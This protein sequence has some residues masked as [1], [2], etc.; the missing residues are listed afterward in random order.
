MMKML[1]KPYFWIPAL[2]GIGIFSGMFVQKAIS[3]GDDYAQVQKLEQAFDIINRQYVDNVDSSKLAENAIEGMLEGLDPHSVYINAERMK[4]VNE[5]F[6]GSFEGIGIFFDFVDDTLTVTQ[7]IADG[8]SEKVGLQAGDRIMKI[9]GVSTVGL[10]QEDVPRKLKGPKGTT[11]SIEV[12]R[13]GIRE[14]KSFTITRDTI[15]FNTVLATHMIDEQTGYIRLER[16]ARTTYDEV[17]GGILSLKS[18]GM[19]RLIL[20]LRGNRGGYMNQAIAIVDEFLPANRKIVFTKSRIPSFVEEYRSTGRGDFEGNPVIVLVDEGSASASE[21]VA[22]ALQDHDRGLIVGQR[23]FGKGLVQ[24]QFELLDGSV[25]QMTISRY[26]TPSGRLIQ[27]KYESGNQE[28]YYKSKMTGRRDNVVDIR[29]I[30][31][32]APDS[33]KFKTTHGRTVLGGGGI[34]PDFVIPDSVDVPGDVVVALARKSVED[35]FTGRWLAQSPEFR[36]EWQNKK[37]QFINNFQLS[38]ADWRAFKAF[39]ESKGIKLSARQVGTAKDRTEFTEAEFN[40]NKKTIEVRLKAFLARRMW[41]RDSMTRVF[42]QIDP[43]MKQA[44]KLWNEAM[45]FATNQ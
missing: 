37:S 29:Q 41:D 27:T 21:I 39:S 26:F 45:S 23:T 32:E 36:N 4:G 10:K 30:I 13:P 6:Q 40:A 34:L 28:A 20:D 38:D 35:D 19:K 25:L 18:Q 12:D 14:A 43:V 24:R 44:M 8:P 15:P 7:V 42:H 1:K 3:G 31:D 16:F 17:H 33:L 9:D 11:V 2:L 5:E 22:G